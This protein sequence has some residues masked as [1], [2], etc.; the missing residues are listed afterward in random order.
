MAFRGKPT[1]NGSG[2]LLNQARGE[3][4]PH[5]NDSVLYDGAGRLRSESLISESD[6]RPYADVLHAYQAR[7]AAKHNDAVQNWPLLNGWNLVQA[8]Y[9]GWTI[10]LIQDDPFSMLTRLSNIGEVDEAWVGVDSLDASNVAVARRRL[11]GFLSPSK[12]DALLLIPPDGNMEAEFADMMSHHEQAQGLSPMKIF[13]SHKGADKPRVREFKKTLEQLGFDPWLDEDAMRAGTELERGILKGFS[14]SCAAVFFITANFKDEN[15][16]ASEVNYAL[17]EKRKKGDKF[18]IITI[19]FDAASRSNVPD[20]L[21]QY[22]WKEPVSDLEAFREIVAALPVQV[23][24]VR[25]R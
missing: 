18:A 19:V 25:W 9:R 3:S 4:T 12:R 24:D 7:V 14:E 21:H 5:R 11:R 2:Y 1:A 6:Q 13:L 15:F 10:V 17:S 20:L 8:S 22:V 16:L 23:G